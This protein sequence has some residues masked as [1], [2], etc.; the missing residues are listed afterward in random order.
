MVY[1]K[2]RGE[3]IDRIF[4][5]FQHYIQEQNYFDIV[6][7]EKIGYVWLLVDQPSD[8]VAD[9]L[10]SPEAMLDSLFNDIIIDVVFS[11]SNP[12][13]IPNSLI[14]SE[15]EETE[16]RRRI[17][18]ILET[19]GDDKDFCLDYLEKYLKEYQKNALDL[20]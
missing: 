10:D 20:T 7:S 9:V 13:H 4:K 6:Y 8:A 3:L 19:M 2:E 15:Y 5:A 16:S 12:Y 14:L 1:S 17:T 18:A 11:P